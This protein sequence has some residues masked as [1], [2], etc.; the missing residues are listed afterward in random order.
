[1][2]KMT[3]GWDI[4][5]LFIWIPMKTK[6]VYVLNNRAGKKRMISMLPAISA[7]EGI[8]KVFDSFAKQERVKRLGV[9]DT[10]SKLSN[11]MTL[12]FKKEFLL[13]FSEATVPFLSRTI[14][15]GSARNGF[16]EKDAAVENIWEEISYTLSQLQ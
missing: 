16:G 13:P 3:D 14:Y 5:L 4:F 10:E 7:G 9:M 15:F 11:S 1:L 12:I 6:P 8:W 2:V